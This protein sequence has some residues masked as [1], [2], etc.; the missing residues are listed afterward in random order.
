MLSHD[1]FTWTI[2]AVQNREGNPDIEKGRFVS[3][4]PLAYA[5]AL[6][7]DVFLTFHKGCHIFFADP[8]ALQGTL[9]ETLKEVK[10]HAFFSIP[11]IWEKIYSRLK[12]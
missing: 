11:R 5:G 12:K 10:P 6:F 9:L 4:L 1:N 2:K 3:Y 7:F 8:S